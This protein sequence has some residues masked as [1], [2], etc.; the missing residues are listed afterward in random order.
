M[1]TYRLPGISTDCVKSMGPWTLLIL[2]SQCYLI[3]M[4][5]EALLA[6]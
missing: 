4:D 5:L 6:V 2:P 1:V 3:R